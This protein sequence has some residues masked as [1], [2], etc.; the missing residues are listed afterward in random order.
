[1]ADTWIWQRRRLSPLI[2]ALASQHAAWQKFTNTNVSFDPALDSSSFLLQI[3]KCFS[4][5]C[6]L[7]LTFTWGGLASRHRNIGPS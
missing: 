6:T 7:A 3:D 5:T 1:M 4:R 2:V